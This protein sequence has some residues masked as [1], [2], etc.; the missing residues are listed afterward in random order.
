MQFM[1][2]THHKGHLKFDNAD[3]GSVLRFATSGVDNMGDP[4]INRLHAG[5]ISLHADLLVHGSLPNRSNRRRCGFTSLLS[6]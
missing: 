2:Q 4:Y 5:Q 1:P 3:E 6:A